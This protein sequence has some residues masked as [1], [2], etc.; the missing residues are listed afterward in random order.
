MMLGS[1][2]M[3]SPAA[4]KAM[5]DAA[6]AAG[7]PYVEIVIEPKCAA[8]YFLHEIKGLMSKE[9][10]IGDVILIADV[11]QINGYN[12]DQMSGTLANPSIQYFRWEAGPV[13]LFLSKSS[14]TLPRSVQP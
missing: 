9:L 6:K 5:L 8:A 10:K 4:N 2:Q 12:L 11:R 13:T 1:P 7:I 3:W 14:Q